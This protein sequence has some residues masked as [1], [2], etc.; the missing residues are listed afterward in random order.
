MMIVEGE[1]RNLQGC[2]G[3][4]YSKVALLAYDHNIA[5]LRQVSNGGQV[6]YL[7]SLT[8]DRKAAGQIHLPCLLIVS[9]YVLAS[10][11]RNV[12]IFSYSSWI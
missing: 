8:I 6:E 12:P 7:L 5:R 1:I 3:C 10:F 2:A 11:G 4:R 9:P